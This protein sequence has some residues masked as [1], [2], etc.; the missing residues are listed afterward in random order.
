MTQRLAGKVALI[1]GGASGI[2]A[3]HVRVFA[4]A[5]A[6]VVAGDVQE[7]WGS[8]WRKRSGRPAATW[9]SSSSM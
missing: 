7:K 4:Q 9:C 6:R 2:G 5:G 3:A 8:P 1:T